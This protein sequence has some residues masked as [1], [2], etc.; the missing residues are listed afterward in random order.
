MRSGSVSF[1]RSWFSLPRI[2]T[3]V[4]VCVAAC[5]AVG[6]R[7]DQKF[8]KMQHDIAKIMAK[9]TWED[10]RK[11]YYEPNFKGVDMEAR[12]READ[13]KIDQAQSYGQVFV[14]IQWALDG[15][16][17]SHTFFIPPARP[18][19]TEY[20]WRMEMYGNKCYVSAEI[21]RAHV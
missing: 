1:R 10:V 21:G 18:I 9:N 15:L 19:R 20:G 6:A 8:G 17:D 16:H 12:F 4:V 11:N 2:M 13:Q 7:S 5:L 14:T 3:V